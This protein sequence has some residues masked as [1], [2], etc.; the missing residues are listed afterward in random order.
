MRFI[1][2][3]ILFSLTACSAPS[4]EQLQ[5]TAQQIAATGVA[6]TLQALPTNTLPPTATNT[7]EPTATQQA[8]ATPQ[9]TATA[10]VA[11]VS[12]NGTQVSQLPTKPAFAEADDRTDSRTPVLLQNNTDQIIWVVLDGP[13]YAEYRFSDTFLILLEHGDY[14][15]RAWIGSKGPFEGNFRLVNQDKHLLIFSAN[16]VQFIGP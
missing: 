3:L 11:A 10:T 12:V 1:A 15:Y 13:V 5:A 4:L 9:T 2:T 8:T 16:K 7:A 6:Q 14:H